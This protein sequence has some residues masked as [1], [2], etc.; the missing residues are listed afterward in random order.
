MLKMNRTNSTAEIYSTGFYVGVILFHCVCILVGSIGNFGVIGYNIFM[1][2]SKTPTT[3][4]IVNLAISDVIVCLVFFPPW[5]AKYISLFLDLESNFKLICVIGKISSI[6]SLGLSII[7]LLAITVDKYVFITKPLEYP[8]IMTWKRTY[9]LLAI[10]WTSAIVNINFIFFNLETESIPW[11]PCRVKNQQQLALY[12]INIFIPIALI[13]FF[14]YKIYRVAKQQNRRIR[15][16]SRIKS[17]STIINISQHSIR[18]ERLRQIKIVK[19]FAI[20]LGVLVACLL[21]MAIM[22]TLSQTI[23]KVGCLPKSFPTF[24]VMLVGANS[25]MNPFIYSIRNK[26]YTIFYR[27]LLSKPFKNT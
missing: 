19:T 27:N 25:V 5:L 6:T 2:H 17:Q 14:N 1:N 4:F 15:N 11:N 3:Y 26:E 9:V 10:I 18:K 7:N 16:E 12:I 20:I 23:C 22:Y 13:F 21:P 24:C 8:R